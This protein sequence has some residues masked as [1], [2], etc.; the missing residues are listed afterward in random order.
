MNET[1]KV[2]LTDSMDEDDSEHRDQ[3]RTLRV[4]EPLISFE[5]GK[6]PVLAEVESKA[7][8]LPLEVPL[9]ETED[10]PMDDRHCKGLRY[11][12]DSNAGGLQ[13]YADETGLNAPKLENSISISFG[14]KQELRAAIELLNFGIG[15]NGTSKPRDDKCNKEGNVYS[16]L[17]LPSIID[18]NHL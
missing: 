15:L 16:T 17:Q 5:N 18:P 13:A 8:V 2:M 12:Y 14:I 9:D 3:T 7:S 6:H 11:L 1:L 4:Q 10:S